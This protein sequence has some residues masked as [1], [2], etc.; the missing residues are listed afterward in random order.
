MSD[1]DITREHSLPR[2]EIKQRIESALEE[3]PG[4][5]IWNGDTLVFRANS[6]ASGSVE[7]TATSL[8]LQARLPFLLRGFA[9][10]IRDRIN[11]RLD[12]ALA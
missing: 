1:I 9:G 6:G 11:A 10:T 3:L 8:R 4:S 7:L 5:Y 12:E 2:E